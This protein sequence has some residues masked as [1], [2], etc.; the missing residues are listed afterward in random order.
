M[1]LACAYGQRHAYERPVKGSETDSMLRERV[2]NAANRAI[3]LNSGA[4]NILIQT[5]KGGNPGEDDLASLKP[6]EVL[7]KILGVSNEGNE[8]FHERT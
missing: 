7:E 8:S 3:Q 2:R 1:Y 4:R 5:Y 6:D